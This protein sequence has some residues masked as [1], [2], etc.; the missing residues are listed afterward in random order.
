MHQKILIL[1]ISCKKIVLKPEQYRRVFY[2]KP[3]NAQKRGI[4]FFKSVF[5]PFFPAHDLTAGIYC[6]SFASYSK[7]YACVFSNI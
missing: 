7:F 4:F 2:F 3:P 6:I 5:I 1:L